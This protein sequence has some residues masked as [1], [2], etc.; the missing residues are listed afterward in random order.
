V[1]FIIGLM[2]ALL[3]E[4][5]RMRGRKRPPEEEAEGEGEGEAA[6]DS[7]ELEPVALEPATVEGGGEADAPGGDELEEVGLDELEEELELEEE[8]VVVSEPGKEG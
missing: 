5:S 8:A 3:V 7:V 2:L 6:M 1:A 4:E